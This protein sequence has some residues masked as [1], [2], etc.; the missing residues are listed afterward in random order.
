MNQSIL[1]ML[2]VPYTATAIVGFLIYRGVKKNSEY[3][4]AREQAR[5][6]AGPRPG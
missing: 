4:K 1:F 2:A 6:A 5:P 3:L